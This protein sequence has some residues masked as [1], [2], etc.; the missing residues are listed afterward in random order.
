MQVHIFGATSSPCCSNKALRQTANDNEEKY[1]KEVAETI[2]RSF[3]VDDLLKSTRTVHQE[4]TLASKLIAML[5]EGGFH[6]TKFLSNRREVLLTLPNQERA[7]PTLD[8]QLDRLP[9][10]RTLGLH[11]DVERDIFCFNCDN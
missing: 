3:Y 11:W 2:R 8:L 9:V 5:E 7:N 1:G 4:S 10:N 6:L